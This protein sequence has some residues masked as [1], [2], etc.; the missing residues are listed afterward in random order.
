MQANSKLIWMGA[1]V[2][3]LGGLAA[4]RWFGPTGDAPTYV[5]DTADTQTDW[6]CLQCNT[7]IKLTARQVEDWRAS[8]DKLAPERGRGVVTRF[9]CDKCKTFTVV[10]AEHCAD[11]D[12]WF[13]LQ[14][15]EGRDGDCAACRKAM[16]LPPLKR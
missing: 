12:V 9:L 6:M 1:I 13:P 15:L 11:H 4:W 16:G 8:S 7:V 14:D 5:P 10:R 3:V 2:V